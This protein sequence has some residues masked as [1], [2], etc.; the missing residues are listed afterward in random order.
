MAFEIALS[1][2]DR[3]IDVSRSLFVARHPSETLA[4]VALRVLGWCALY[5]EGLEFGPGLCDGEA[6]DLLARDDGGLVR[7]W[8]ACG[9]VP[10]EK[11]RKALSATAGGGGPGNAPAR[12]VAFFGETRRAEEL[13]REIAELPRRPKEIGRV[14]AWTVDQSLVDALAQ[15][16]RRQAWTVTVVEGHL[17]VDANG[18]SHEGALTRT[19]FD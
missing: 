2:A 11:V 16:T 12:V 3:G 6:P 9:R 14:E 17:Y 19:R 18:A 13:A 5:E 4:H 7:T 10:W 15:D 1:V 8:V